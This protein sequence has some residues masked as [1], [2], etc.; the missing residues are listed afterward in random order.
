M[1]N[2][3]KGQNP[4][5]S[6][7]A[8]AL[9]FLFFKHIYNQQRHAVTKQS[10][11]KKKKK[12]LLNVTIYCF[13]SAGT[14]QDFLASN[15]VKPVGKF[16]IIKKKL[17]LGFNDAP[18]VRRTQ[19][20]DANFPNT[21]RDSFVVRWCHTFW[22]DERLCLQNSETSERSSAPLGFLQDEWSCHFCGARWGQGSWNNISSELSAYLLCNASR[23]ADH[24]IR[25]R[26]N[27]R[28][29]RRKAAHFLALI[30]PSRCGAQ[31]TVSRSSASPLIHLKHRE[32]A[33]IVHGRSRSRSRSKSR[34][35]GGGTR[36][37]HG[38]ACR[39]MCPKE[40]PTHVIVILKLHCVAKEKREWGWGAKWQSSHSAQI[41]F[42]SIKSTQQ[43]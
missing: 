29:G 4:K 35:T 12:P 7:A 37:R 32:R 13:L 25:C 40:T 28:R 1:V 43:S 39:C 36:P 33:S 34:S 31:W 22:S 5:L 17:S 19:S 20:R 24:Q 3:V 41:V 23:Q 2:F 21:K 10:P 8:K 11:K 14:K 18:R 38:V 16:E 26:Q 9:F 15:A 42:P 6:P 27:M 30:V